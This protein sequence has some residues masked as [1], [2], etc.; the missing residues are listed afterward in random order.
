MARWVYG[1][2]NTGTINFLEIGDVGPHDMQ[3]LGIMNDLFR[4]Q[5]FTINQ[6]SQLAED[7]FNFSA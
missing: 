2:P 6:S 4:Y 3:P 7:G 5:Q 1:R